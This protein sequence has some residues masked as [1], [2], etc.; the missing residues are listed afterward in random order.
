MDGPDT[1]SW[2]RMNGW[3]DGWMGV[4]LRSAAGVGKRGGRDDRAR[5]LKIM[6]PKRRRAE[7]GGRGGGV[8]Q[9]WGTAGCWEWL[10]SKFPG[11][12]FGGLPST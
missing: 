5:V 8:F 10:F 12:P 4:T 6:Q 1:S 9:R 7:L 11:L 2:R 3:M